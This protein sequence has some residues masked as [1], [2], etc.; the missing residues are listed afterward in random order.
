MGI[1]KYY[2]YTHDLPKVDEH[3]KAMNIPLKVDIIVVDYDAYTNYE[4]FAE[5]PEQRYLEDFGMLAYRA[6][7]YYKIEHHYAHYMGA[8]WL[9]GDTGNGLVIDG[10]GD[11]GV[12]ISV[13]KD[14]NRV[15]KLTFLNMCSIGD[16]YKT[17][18]LQLLG[19]GNLEEWKNN[20]HLDL[21]G[22]FMGLISYGNFNQ[23]YADYLRQFDLEEMVTN[24]FNMSAYPVRGEVDVTGATTEWASEES[25]HTVLQWHIDY[26]KTVQTVLAEKIIEFTKRYFESGITS[27]FTK[28]E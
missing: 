12:H 10:C 5:I 14:R 15:K 24:A 13:F 26:F 23:K 9:Y 17:T 8:E 19:P 11:E 28:L 20:G 16:L 3:Q 6:D 4:L 2:P 21:S 18:A 27:S 22:N 1:K 7:K 25:Y